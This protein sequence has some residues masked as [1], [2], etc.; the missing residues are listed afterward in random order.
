MARADY[1]N[2][3]ARVYW[4]ITR[5]CDLACLHCRAEAAP[6]ADPAEL[7]TERG[8]KLLD[9]LAE[10]TPRPHVVLTGGDPLKRADLFQLIAHAR[11]RG[12][13]VSVSPSATPLL[14][15]EAIDRLRTASV[16]AISLSIDGA[17]AESH[18]AL[19]GVPGTFERT[20]AAGKR[21][22]EV[23]LPFQV[24][25]LVSQETL[26]ELPAIEA[27]VR[28]LDANRWSLFFLVTVG[29]GTVLSPI[30]PQETETLLVWLA[31]RAKVPG[32]VITTTEA[33]HF[34]RV[35]MQHRDANT[36]APQ[37][38]GAG[39]RDGNGI[40]FISNDGEIHP[41]GFLPLGAGN[42]KME[43]PL[44]VYREAPM[45]KALR[46]VDSFHGRCGRCEF[47]KVCGGSR[48]R[49]YAATGDAYAEDPLCTYEPALKAAN[50]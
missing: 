38:H 8:L 18:D 26:A 21:A 6:L 40:M 12:L 22:R 4:E 27:L 17:T 48:A 43:N 19:R 46:D 3:P 14:T 1:D 41:S 30:S 35:A 16:S 24:N 45:F 20:M 2:A 11:K 44:R 32:M 29:R 10:A 31:E 47:R 15:E 7:D 9:Q 37:G 13:D 42:V 25:T 23:G 28:K 39:I 33:P 34:R 50:A 49:A 5:A 36:P